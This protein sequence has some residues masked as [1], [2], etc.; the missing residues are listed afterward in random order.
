MDQIAAQCTAAQLAGGGASI[1]EEKF[2]K[3]RNELTEIATQL[4]TSSKALVAT[5][6]NTTPASLPEHLS[7]SL[8]AL[9]RITELAQDMTKHTSSPLQTRNIV[10][11]V[12]DVASSFRELANV[13]IGPLGA[14]AQALQA[15]CLSNV[16]TTLI[17]SLRVFSP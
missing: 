15:E 12:H 10:L 6:S 4:V 9:R 17:R 16:L 3:S 5:M 11:K 7:T 8:T 14:G 1:D 13:Q 2:Q